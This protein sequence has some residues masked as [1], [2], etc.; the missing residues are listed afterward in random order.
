M[1]EQIAGGFKAGEMMI[2]AAGD[3]TGKSK[4]NQVQEHTLEEMLNEHSTYDSHRI[5]TNE[6]KNLLK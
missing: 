2:I 3:G 5:E 1:F 6:F 4:Y